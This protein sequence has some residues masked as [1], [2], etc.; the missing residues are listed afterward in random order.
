ML[1]NCGAGEDSWE[2]PLD[3][4]K[5]KPDNPKR[6]Q[7]LMF[8]GTADSEAPILWP[9][10][11]KSQIIGKDPDAGKYWGQEEKGAQRMRQL[12]DRWDRGWDRL[13]GHEFEPTPGDSEGQESLVCSS[14]WGCKELDTTEQLNWTDRRKAPGNHDHTTTQYTFALNDWIIYLG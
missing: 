2:S 8:I 5:I 11:T 7:P 1:L 3:G 10:D 4:S 13:N 12:R 9:S 14:P 6:N